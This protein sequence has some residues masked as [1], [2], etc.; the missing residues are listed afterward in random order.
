[1]QT[2]NDLFWPP[3]MAVKMVSPMPCP[4]W[5]KSCC[6]PLSLGRS[7][8]PGEVVLS[9]QTRIAPEPRSRRTAA[10]LGWPRC[11]WDRARARLTSCAPPPS[12]PPGSWS[13]PPTASMTGS[14]NLSNFHK[15]TQYHQQ[16]IAFSSD[17]VTQ[18][19]SWGWVTTSWRLETP[20]NKHSRYEIS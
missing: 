18:T 16:P 20:V 1:M 13:P 7:S 10:F 15:I 6:W 19:G 4:L 9:G 17:I 5:H 14:H 11:S 2:E 3:E 12:S 8:A